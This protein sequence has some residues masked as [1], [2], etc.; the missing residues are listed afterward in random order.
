[1][2]DSKEEKEKM[3]EETERKKERR[4]EEPRWNLSL[5]RIKLSIIERVLWKLLCDFDGKRKKKR[6]KRDKKERREGSGE[7][8]G[9]REWGEKEKEGK[10]VIRKNQT[11]DIRESTMEVV[12]DTCDS[13]VGQIEGS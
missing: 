7:G 13:V 8:K 10:P 4:K 11:L 12:G 6:R 5:E 2:F 9:G 1:M 3:G